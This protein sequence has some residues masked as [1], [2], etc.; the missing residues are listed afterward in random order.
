MNICYALNIS[1]TDIVVQN[2]FELLKIDIQKLPCEIKYKRVSPKN[3]D[4]TKIEKYLQSVLLDRNSTPT[5]MKEVA[6]K[7][8][9]NQRTL[10][11]HF[12][13]LC[14]AISEKYRNYRA[15]LSK[16]NID[17]SCREVRQA[18]F[19][20]IKRGEYPSE[21]RVSQLI[22]KPGNFRYK[23]VKMALEEVKSELFF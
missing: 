21:A 3:L 22:T 16:R 8:A 14:Q 15:K 13:E 18:V 7:L 5:T 9:V 6:R 11:K 10:S 1:I 2:E 20:L 12:P 4:F 17:I 19:T 23:K